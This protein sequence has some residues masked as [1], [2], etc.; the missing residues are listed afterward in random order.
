VSQC[1]PATCE[2]RQA[3]PASCDWRLSDLQ[4]A[5]GPAFRATRDLEHVVRVDEH[6]R[7][8]SLAVNVN[9]ADDRLGRECAS[10]GLPLSTAAAPQPLLEVDPIRATTSNGKFRSAGCGREPCFP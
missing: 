10:N 8:H 3:C 6:R 4:N 7:L 2:A 9:A 5:N 1:R